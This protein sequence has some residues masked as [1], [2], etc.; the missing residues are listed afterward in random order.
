MPLSA[1]CA[2]ESPPASVD[3][4]ESDEPASR[5]GT[6]GGS[7]PESIPPSVGGTIGGSIAAS[8]GGAMGGSMAA[9]SGGT[10]GVTTGLP[11]HAEATVN[12]AATAA[13]PTAFDTNAGALG[14]G[15]SSTSRRFV[16]ADRLAPSRRSLRSR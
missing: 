8:C 6:I 12:A 15:V 7:R 10:M 1:G 13:C 11:P 16:I 2:P 5:G 3:A 14:N 4:P 9:S